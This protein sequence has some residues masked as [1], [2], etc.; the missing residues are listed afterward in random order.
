MT[1]PAT[2]HQII[3]CDDIAFISVIL[4][5]SMYSQYPQSNCGDILRHLTPTLGKLLLGVCLIVLFTTPAYADVSKEG[6]YISLAVILGMLFL[7]AV[8]VSMSRR[9]RKKLYLI[10]LILWAVTAFAYLWFT[11]GS[12]NE[13]LFTSTVPYIILVVYF[14]K[15][16]KLDKALK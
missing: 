4:T 12:Q 6:F 7:P 2:F 14:F 1:T 16:K 13:F 10:V 9:T 8:I 5:K 11:G 3:L 15:E